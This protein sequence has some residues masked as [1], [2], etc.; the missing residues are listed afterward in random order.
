VPSEVCEKTRLLV[1]KEWYKKPLPSG[2]WFDG[3]AYIDISGSRRVLRPDIDSL[4]E[5]YVVDENVKIAAYNEL[6]VD[7]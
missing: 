3:A 7:L 1:Q 6:L 4:V 5:L 2:W